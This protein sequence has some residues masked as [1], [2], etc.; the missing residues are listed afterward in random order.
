MI[1]ISEKS[2]DDK[3]EVIQ[4]EREKT[5]L[6]KE[7]EHKAELA[8]KDAPAKEPVKATGIIILILLASI[9]IAIGGILFINRNNK[10][11]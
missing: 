5:K 11:D 2:L 4:N 3:V 9:A 10:K 7:A 1:I 8:A 6:I